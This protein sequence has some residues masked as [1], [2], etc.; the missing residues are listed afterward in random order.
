MLTPDPLESQEFEIMDIYLYYVA[1]FSTVGTAVFG[2]IGIVLCIF[3][4]VRGNSSNSFT[5]NMAYLLEGVIN[6]CVGAGA[7]FWYLD[8]SFFKSLLIIA[9]V[10]ALSLLQFY[11]KRY[12]PKLFD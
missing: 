4:L 9:I 10:S 8:G 11:T 2:L 7:F 5:T 1:V 12:Y 3:Q 6:L